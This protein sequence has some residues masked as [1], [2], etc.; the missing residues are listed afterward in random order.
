ML[1]REPMLSTIK[2][3][4]KNGWALLGDL[5]KG[6]PLQLI[7]DLGPGELQVA[8]Q[9]RESVNDGGRSRKRLRGPEAVRM[10]V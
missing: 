3:H 7:L 5:V 6:Q 10:Q 8:D 4:V 9:V 1:V 2:S